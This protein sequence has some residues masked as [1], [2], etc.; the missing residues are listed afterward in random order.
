[1]SS[2]QACTVLTESLLP[3]KLIALQISESLPD[4]QNIY[5]APAPLA[6]EEEDEFLQK[7]SPFFSVEKTIYGGRGCFSKQ[8]IA[9]GTDI[10]HVKFPLGSSVVRPFRKEIC[11]WCFHYADGRSMK[12]RIKEKIYFCSEKCVSEFTKYDHD[13]SLT[14]TMCTAEELFVKCAGELPEEDMPKSE[15]ELLQAIGEKW[16]SVAD[17]ENRVFRMKPT[18]RARYYPT[19]TV[20]DY[21]EIRYVI[22]TLYNINR[23]INSTT[24][25]LV[26]ISEN[27]KYLEGMDFDEAMRFEIKAFNS[28]QS[29]ELDKVK[30]YPYMLD[31]F[32]NIYKFVRLVIP[33]S[34]LPTVTPQT[35]RT[36]IGRN[37]TNAFG[38]WS[39]ITQEDEEREFFGFCV[40]PSAS[41]FNHSCDFNIKKIRTGSSYK[42]VAA[43]DILPG[44]ELCISYGIDGDENV[45]KRQERL[46][47]WFFTCGCKKCTAELALV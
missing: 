1:M 39:L 9:K 35:I 31:S 22:S 29:S 11:T 25:P 23:C 17:W 44:D 18:K 24:E 37:L 5:V 10:L 7:I 47:E 4:H 16:E 15:E 38:T 14:S 21:A 27:E 6:T 12:F 42:F 20:D 8:K 2:N 32:T 28:L 40:Y 33:E 36:I 34:W 13:G 3:E 46:S 26:T 43:K 45:E 41:Y 19:V 30:K